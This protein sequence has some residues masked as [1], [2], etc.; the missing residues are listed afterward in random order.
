[1][2]TTILILSVLSQFSRNQILQLQSTP[3]HPYRQIH[4]IVHIHKHTHAYQ[5]HMSILDRKRS[6]SMDLYYLSYSE[7]NKRQGLAT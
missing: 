5:T 7:V 4:T 2:Y 6:N 3:I 1:M